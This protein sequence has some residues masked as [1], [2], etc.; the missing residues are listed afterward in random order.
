MRISSVNSIKN[1]N[2]FCAKKTNN[3]KP[4]SNPLSQ[5][6]KLLKSGL[7]GLAIIGAAAVGYSILKKQGKNPAKIVKNSF[8]NVK[9]FLSD[10]QQSDPIIQKLNGKRDAEA[11]KLYK[12]HAAVKKMNSLHNKL[13]SGYF[14]GKPKS[15]FDALR[16]NEVKL[17]REA[18]VVL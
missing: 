13:L 11:V 17:K 1:S 16:K 4:V 7:E 15:V 5:K 8:D 9:R 10:K 14:D 3:E 18:Q 6:E 2:H 12:G